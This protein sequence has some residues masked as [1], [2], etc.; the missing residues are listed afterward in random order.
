[1]AERRGR[2]WHKRG[3]IFRP[4]GQWG[5]MN[6][7]AQVPTAL[8]LE[9]R[10]RVYVA[11]RPKA[12]VSLTGYVDLDIEDPGK[13][14][15]I[16]SKPIL[17][18]GGPGSFDEHGIMPSAVVRDGDRVRLYYSGWSRLAGVAPYHNTTG[19]AVSRDGGQTFA[20]EYPGPVLDRSPVEPFSATSPCVV[21]HEG[22][23]HMFYSSGLGWLEIDG[24]WEHIYDL[25]HAS[26][27]DGVEWRRTAEP[28]LPQTFVEEALTR[29]TILRQGD[30][31]D[32]WFSH[33]GSRNFRSDGDVYRIGFAHSRDLWTWHRDDTAA[34]IDISGTGFDSE[35]IAYPCVIRVGSR[36][37]MFY[38]G[39]GF[40]RDGFAWA[41][42][43]AA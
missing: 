19:L 37:I 22:T 15:T 12:G 21:E 41:E 4:Q 29:P 13:V 42:W 28:A 31:W 26:S 5:W 7:H 36:I 25:R 3:L 27:S 14:I 18:L 39:N 6:S 10:I 30:G 23:W 32:M 24:K 43:T 1:V 34:G 38:N 35:M 20:R 2:C 33:R 9:D 16:S 8:V 40:G 11:S 17:D